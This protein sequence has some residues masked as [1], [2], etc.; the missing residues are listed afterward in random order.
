MRRADSPS[1]PKPR[2]TRALAPVAALGLALMVAG[3]GFNVREELG[4]IGGGPDEFA[5]VKKKPLVMPTNTSA[6]PEP[7]PGAP[8]LVDPRPSE[9][10][11]AA[12]TGR[13]GDAARTN[14]APGASEQSFLAAAGAGAADPNI[15]TELEADE[16]NPNARL[17]DGLLGKSE[18]EADQVGRGGRSRAAGGRGA[19]G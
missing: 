17:L 13:S 4:L 10:A 18:E 19:R 9:A 2:L 6:L 3:C 8:S 11:Q 15:R 16:E 14:A 12:L 1:R 7:K 5:V